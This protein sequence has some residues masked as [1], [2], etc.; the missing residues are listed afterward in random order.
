ML[1]PDWTPP[2]PMVREFVEQ[3]DVVVC[4]ETDY[5]SQ[6]AEIAASANK[7]SV[8][9]PMWEWLGNPMR[10]PNFDRYICTSRITYRK[11]HVDDSRKRYLPWPVDTNLF[12][13]PNVKDGDRPLDLP[14]KTVLHCAGH[15]G[16]NGRKG[17]L[18]AVQG[19]LKTSNLKM[20]LRSQVPLEKIDPDL[21]RLREDD[22]I[23]VEVDNFCSE[24]LYSEADAYLYPA[25]M[26]GQ[27]MV[28][29]EAMASGLLTFV[30]DAP[31]MNEFQLHPMQYLPIRKRSEKEIAGQTVPW[32]Q[33]DTDK[34][35]ERLE[36]AA[37]LANAEDIHGTIARDES[38]DLWRDFWSEALT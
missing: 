3:C 15:G 17:T 6:L 14:I 2:L 9:I 32:V 36:W 8:L 31:P 24:D 4:V 10:C 11:T 38:W 34:I 30:T 29:Q 25:R 12:K 27:A 18:E 35:A 19:F 37:D 22:R 7:L 16:I 33:C 26:D 28:P 21:P 23:T 20:I 1:S 13:W 5:R